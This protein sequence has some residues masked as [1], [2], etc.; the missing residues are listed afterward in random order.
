MLLAF[1]CFLVA[2]EQDVGFLTVDQDDERL[3]TA[4]S[5]ISGLLITLLDNLVL[6]QRATG[7]FGN[8][9][10]DPS[11]P[12]EISLAAIFVFSVGVADFLS[13]DPP[14]AQSVAAAEI[15]WT[16]LQGRTVDGFA[17]SDTCGG[18]HLGTNADFYNQNVGMNEGPGPAL[19]L[20]AKLGA[21]LLGFC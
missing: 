6:Y 7:A 13:I 14:S 17:V 4:R 12:D 3:A 21:G 1:S 20:Y 8:V 19:L 18:Q 11:S 5:E 9:V 16:W 2:T 15:A 10:N